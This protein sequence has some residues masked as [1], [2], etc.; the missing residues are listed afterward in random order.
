MKIIDPGAISIRTAM[1]AGHMYALRSIIGHSAPSRLTLNLLLAC[2][3][4][5]RF[6]NATKWGGSSLVYCKRCVKPQGAKT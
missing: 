5:I 2:G 4:I 3:H 6:V 1:Q